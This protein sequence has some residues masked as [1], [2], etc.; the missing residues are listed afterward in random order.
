MLIARYNPDG[1]ADTSFG[2]G[3]GRVTVNV[4]NFQ[5]SPCPTATSSSAAT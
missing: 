1:S 3:D 4:G 5:G 2:G